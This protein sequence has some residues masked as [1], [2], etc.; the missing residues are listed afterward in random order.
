MWKKLKGSKGTKEASLDRVIREWLS[1]VILET[2]WHE[3]KE[4][5]PRE[6]GVGAKVI[7]LVFLFKN[8]KVNMAGAQWEMK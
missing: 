5:F 2:E 3:K 7:G 1:E 4:E 8:S 6:V